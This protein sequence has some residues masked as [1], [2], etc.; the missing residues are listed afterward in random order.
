MLGVVAV[1]AAAFGLLLGASHV[2]AGRVQ[3]QLSTIQ[4]RYVRRLELAP[5]FEAGVEKLS[6][7]F[8]DAV[9]AG[10]SFLLD[11][12]RQ[13]REALLAQV[14]AAGGGIE[15][16]DRAS[17]QAAVEGY[18]AAGED[19]SR[20]L[21]AK[22]TGEAMVERISQMQ[23][24]LGQL[25]ELVHKA[26]RLER[27]DL[28]QA[29]AAAARAWEAGAQLSLWVSL[30]C[31]LVVL[32]ISLQLG[33]SLMQSVAALTAGFRRFGAGD[34]TTPIP[35]MGGAELVEAAQQANEMASE[36][37]QARGQLLNKQAEL[38]VANRELEAFSYSV[39]HDLRAPLRG[40]RG[41]AEVLLADYGDALGAQGQDY[42]REVLDAAGEMGQLIDALLSLSRVTRAPLNTQPVDL[43]S[44]AR[45][46]V[47]GLVASQPRSEYELLVMPDVTARADPQLMRAVLENLLGNAWKFTSK[48]AR[49]R[50]EFGVRKDKGQE[51]FYVR[52]NGAGFDP[53]HAG[54]LFAPFQR[55]H[56]ARDFPG[57]GIGLATVQRIIHRHGGRIWAVG[58]PGE[59]A[60]FSFTLG[61]GAD[62]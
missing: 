56:T 47:E 2:I 54:K 50:I 39:A 58:A 7:M 25:R 32:L 43:G 21:I 34:F 29:F 42:L 46:V 6:R 51:V 38:E 11:S 23:E 55:L 45:G 30:G 14:Q 52:D 24:K 62:T 35:L 31:L 57:T 3:R 15:P 60:T 26:T 5:R 33:R 4:E 41:F 20:R 48:V 37:E 10:D 8:Q 22:E 12:A 40:V 17:L 44:I 1:S 49:P 13:Q 18:A 27:S 61:P 19:V 53:E 9:A 16:G 28:T 36:I 59:G